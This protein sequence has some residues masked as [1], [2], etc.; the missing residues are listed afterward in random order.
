MKNVENIVLMLCACLSLTSCSLFLPYNKNSYQRDNE[1]R[2][3]SVI[4]L[5]QDKASTN[6]FDYLKAMSSATDNAR[7]KQQQCVDAWLAMNR[8]K[9]TKKL[10]EIKHEELSEHVA[11]VFAPIITAIGNWAIDQ[12]GKQIKKAIDDD[13]EKHVATYEG[14]TITDDIMKDM[15]NPS[16]VL[17]KLDRMIKDKEI[18]AEFKVAVALIPEYQK[19]ICS[20]LNKYSEDFESWLKIQPGTSKEEKANYAK[21]LTMLY[22]SLG[23]KLEKKFNG[24]AVPISA[25]INYSAAKIY[26]PNYYLAWFPVFWYQLFMDSSNDIDI[27]GKLTINNASID[28][29]Y[30]RHNLVDRTDALENYDPCLKNKCA[31]SYAITGINPTK[32]QEVRLL[33]TETDPANIKSI[34]DVATSINDKLTSYAKDELKKEVEK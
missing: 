21:A 33:I 10:A 13:I 18:A 15:D 31:N 22:E 14:S 20:D 19:G 26:Q 16:Y 6:A 32:L 28:I 2:E 24:I 11:P 12:A 5:D 7:A 1:K 27:T 34:S 4:K 30:P 25:R 17:I 9:Y 8:Y 29:S 23:N 3:L